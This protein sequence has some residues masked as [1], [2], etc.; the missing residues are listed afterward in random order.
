M[1]VVQRRRVK[2]DFFAADL[3]CSFFRGSMRKDRKGQLPLIVSVTLGGCRFGERAFTNLN[4]NCA[5]LIGD[6]SI[7][8]LRY[9]WS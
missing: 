7:L 1:S 6:G 4:W 9:C 8:E 2:V 3:T 5:V